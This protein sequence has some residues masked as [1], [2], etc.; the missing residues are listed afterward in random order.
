ML[1]F[2]DPEWLLSSGVDRT[3]GRPPFPGHHNPNPAGSLRL[4]DGDSNAPSTPLG[5]LMGRVR[6]TCCQN[7]LPSE[8]CVRV[9]P[10]RLKQETHRAVQKRFTLIRLKIGVSAL[11]TVKGEQ[12]RGSQTY[13]DHPL[14]EASDG[15]G[16]VPLR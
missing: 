8:P 6:E 3:K 9:P 4:K 2:L 13:L 12:V 5:H 1:M 14:C 11:V 7:S 16:A 10:T 15:G